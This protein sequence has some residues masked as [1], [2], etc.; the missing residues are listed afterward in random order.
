[1]VNETLRCSQVSALTSIKKPTLNARVR[2]LFQATDLIRSGGN[3]ILLK[4]QQVRQVVGDSLAPKSTIGRFLYI[5]NLKGGV[6]KTTL[7]YLITNAASALGLKTCAIDLDIQGNLT[8]QYT[9]IDIDYPVM[10]DVIENKAKIK[11]VIKNVSPTLD[12]IPSSLKNSL[13]QKALL[14]QS[15][16][17]HLTWFNSICLDYLRNNYELIIVDTPPNL[18]TLN[19]VFC[20]CLEQQDHILIPA[21]ADEFSSIGINMFLNDIYDIRNSYNVINS[22]NIFILLNKFFQQQKPQ[23][24]MFVKISQEYGELL[25]GIVIKDSAKIRQIIN[26]KILFN[27][28]KQG[29]EVYEVISNLF[30]EFGILK[31][32]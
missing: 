26:N 12:L 8:K 2:S 7:A 32:V 29:T 28:V 30:K 22:P 17:H 3:R 5:G 19:S 11:D 13:I 16:K 9:E 4:P 18:S 24:E 15:P 6:G 25:S 1:M 27:N 20:L 14:V 10:Y 21:C 23:L 31:A